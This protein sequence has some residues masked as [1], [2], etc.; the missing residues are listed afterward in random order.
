MPQQ[1]VVLGNKADLPAHN[2]V[3]EFKC[4][5]KTVCVANLEGEMLAVDKEQIRYQGPF[6]LGE[7]ENERGTYTATDWRWDPRSGAGDS[8]AQLAVYPLKIENG[9]ILIQLQMADLSQ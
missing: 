1:L 9:R 4:G 6:L 5:D 3:K 8:A 7:N 2:Q